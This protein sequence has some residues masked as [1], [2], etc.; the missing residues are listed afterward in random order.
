MK[1]VDGAF[2]RP[3]IGISKAQAVHYLETRGLQWR[4]DP[5]NQSR[6]YKR[7][8][9]RLDLV[10]LLAE[11]SGGDAALASRLEELSEQSGDLRRWIDQQVGV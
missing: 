3:L 6:V 11:L 2:L 9:V 4:E 1:V 10:P 5:S 7:N 8:R